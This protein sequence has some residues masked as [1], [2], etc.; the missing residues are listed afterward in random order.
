MNFQCRNRSAGSI[1]DN[2]CTIL[3]SVAGGDSA[4]LPPAVT[5][6]DSL[7]SRCHRLLHMLDK[8]CHKLDFSATC[9]LCHNA[10]ERVMKTFVQYFLNKTYANADQRFYI[11]RL[12]SFHTTN[13]ISINVKCE[14]KVKRQNFF[15]NRL[16]TAAEMGK[17]IA[18]LCKA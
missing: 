3:Q 14:N 2:Q 15:H 7:R 6:N 16:C 5:P 10:R 1:F 12:F 17:G 13:P 18:S 9:W 11:N 4:P 8:F